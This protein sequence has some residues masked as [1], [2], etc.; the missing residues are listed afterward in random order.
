MSRI[1]N[2]ESGWSPIAAN[3]AS[4]AY[5]LGQAHP[6]SKMA[7]AGADWRTKCKIQFKWSIDH[8]EQRYGGIVAAYSYWI[9]YNNY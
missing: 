3:P 5:G 2:Y 9:A 4:G 6:G 8:R 1:I 7:S